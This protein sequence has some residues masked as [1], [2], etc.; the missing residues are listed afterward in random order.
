MTTRRDIRRAIKRRMQAFAWLMGD[1]RCPWRREEYERARAAEEAAK[2]NASASGEGDVMTPASIL[3]ALAG[4]PAQDRCVDLAEG[5]RC[6]ICGHAATR[7]IAYARF[8]GSAFTDQNKLR[9][10]GAAN[11]CEPCVWAHA[12][13]VPPG[14]PPPADGKKGVNLR[15]YSHF[16][17]AGEYHAWNKANKREI[18]EW[19]ATPKTGPWFAAIADSGQ[20]HVLPWTPLNLSARGSQVRFEEQSLRL[21]DFAM[22]DALC[23]ALTAG[24]TKE[25]IERGHYGSRAWTIAR[26]HVE[27]LESE[28]ARKHRGGAWFALALWMSQR[29]EEQVAERLSAE[30]TKREEKKTND[31]RRGNTGKVA[32]ADRGSA[33]ADPGRVPGKRRKPAQALGPAAGAVSGGIDAQR[34]VQRVDHEHRSV[35]PLG[36]AIQGSLFDD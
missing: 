34:D 35:V 1:P 9:D 15:L 24:V 13:N 17:H 6:R 22:V 10:W 31:A 19:L 27:S 20:K 36:R 18:R 23:A 12:W 16:W 21:G 29:D 30:K 8:E 7:G 28:W 26:S 11:A 2:V 4:A 25:E 5:Q 33:A 32:R 14:F 3:H